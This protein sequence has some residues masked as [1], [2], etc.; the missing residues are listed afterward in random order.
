VPLAACNPPFLSPAPDVAVLHNNATLVTDPNAYP[1]PQGQLVGVVRRDVRCAYILPGTP[2][3]VV[4]TALFTGG[5]GGAK[6]AANQFQAAN[7]QWFPFCQV[8][9][10]QNPFQVTHGPEAAR[11]DPQGRPGIWLDSNWNN[12][13]GVAATNIAF[14]IAGTAPSTAY[15]FEYVRERSGQ[16]VGL[17]LAQTSDVSGNLAFNGGAFNSS[18]WYSFRF[19]DANA[20]GLGAGRAIS[21]SATCSCQP[22]WH[23][24]APGTGVNLTTI[25]SACATSGALMVTNASAE[26]VRDGLAIGYIV[27]IGETFEALAFPSSNDATTAG[28]A[29]DLFTALSNKKGRVPE[30]ATVGARVMLPPPSR[31]SLVM[32]DISDGDVIAAFIPYEK[33]DEV[34]EAILVF[35][36]GNTPAGGS[37]NDVMYFNGAIGYVLATTNPVIA[38]ARPMMRP[39]AWD[40][41]SALGQC[42]LPEVTTNAGHLKSIWNAIRRTLKMGGALLPVAEAAAAVIPGGQAALPF[43]AGANSAFAAANAVGDIAEATYG[44]A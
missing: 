44:R 42:V 7:G 36:F 13:G 19:T 29:A 12:G 23:V 40:D 41:Y 10:L 4:R 15:T 14:Q 28:N 38:T 21:L 9:S 37:S 20:G 11:L 35:K 1:F 30:S 6:S 5:L 22:L 39:G 34:D 18:G 16:E 32:D 33:N 24:P 26:I 25:E 2:A 17:V 8:T 31:D 3:A 43:L 27:P